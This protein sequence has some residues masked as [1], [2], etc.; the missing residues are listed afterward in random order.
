MCLIQ[1]GFLLK[2]KICAME[3]EG[4]SG[5]DIV[6]TT[7]QRVCRILKIMFKF[8]FSQYAFSNMHSTGSW[9]WPRYITWGIYSCV[10]YSKNTICVA[11]VF[12]AEP[13]NLILDN[14]S[15]LINL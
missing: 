5:L 9:R 8:P 3:E 4:N 2:Q 15:F 1:K 10:S 6:L 11:N 13:L 12:Y 14:P 7:T